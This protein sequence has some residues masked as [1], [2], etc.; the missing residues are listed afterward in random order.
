MISQLRSTFGSG[1]VYHAY[2]FA[3]PE[4]V[5]KKSMAQTCAQALFCTD[6]PEKRPCG[7]CPGCQQFAQGHPDVHYLDLP[8]DKS[9]IPV[10]NVRELIASLSDRA[11]SGGK[12]VIIVRQAELLGSAGQNALLKTLEEPPEDTVFILCTT[13]VNFLLPTVISR[14]Q[15]VRFSPLDETVLAAE[16]VKRGAQKDDAQWLASYC[17]GSMGRTLA[18][19]NDD[20]LLALSRSVQSAFDAA[21][22]GKGIAAAGAFIKA[23]KDDAQEVLGCFETIGR[24]L[25][26]KGNARGAAL[27][28]A[29]WETRKMLRSYVTWQYALEMLLMRIAGE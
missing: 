16:L 10:E 24:A 23:E 12:R 6:S 3:G 1:R 17:E 8:E 9:T 20:K 19:M 13:S 7:T 14:S 18:C 29:V 15:T 4:G 27:L 2:I 22:S 28:E 5:G 11:F 21:V 26:R 25:M